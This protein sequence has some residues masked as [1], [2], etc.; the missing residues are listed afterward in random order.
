[1][2]S[3]RALIVSTS[4]ARGALSGARALADAGWSVGIGTPDGD[5]LAARSRATSRSHIVP[6]PRGDLDEF[7]EAVQRAARAGGYDVVFGGG[8]DWIAA[9]S[10]CADRLG[11]AVAHPEHG[12]V[13][14][15]LDK[16]EIGERARRAGLESPRSV[17]ASVDAVAA[18]SG[19]VVVKCRSHWSP[20]LDHPYRVEARRFDELDGGARAQIDLIRHRGLE[21]L[22]QESVDGPLG[23]LV[24][25]FDGRRL[26][27]RVQQ[28]AERIWPTP[29]G[30]SS[31]AVTVPVDDELAG[32]VESMLADL[33]WWGLVEVQFIH[34]VGGEPQ[35]VDLNPRFYGSMGLALAAG[36]NLPDAWGR[37]A[38]GDALPTLPDGQPGV[39]FLWAAGDLRRAAV[40]R[41][42]G[43]VRDLAST[44]GWAASRRLARVWRPLDPGPAWYL[45]SS[46]ISSAADEA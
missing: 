42:N 11:V 25:V 7:V 39:R 30:M 23:A 2:T 45:I 20:T 22:L 19:P 34:P 3:R 15:G 27:G 41:R 16:L 43:V 12:T 46:R 33:G 44:F 36:G 9:L 21:P 6:R 32:R 40:E 24:G 14:A 17:V 10:A 5:G 18:W 13:V 37:Q 35:L 31:R 28:R 26:L 1:M 29:T 38:L 4:R 8:D